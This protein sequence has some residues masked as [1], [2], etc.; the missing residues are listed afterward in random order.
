MLDALTSSLV[1]S[2]QV[3]YEEAYGF[4]FYYGFVFV[5]LWKYVFFIQSG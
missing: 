4:V 1:Q 2:G 5:F 3:T